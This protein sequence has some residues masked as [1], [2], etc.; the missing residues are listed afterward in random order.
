MWIS[1]VLACVKLYQ[2]AAIAILHGSMRAY[3]GTGSMSIEVT[4]AL[5]KVPACV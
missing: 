1:T 2:M 4:K 3:T 5:S